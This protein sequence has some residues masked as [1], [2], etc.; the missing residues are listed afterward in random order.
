MASKNLSEVTRH[1]LITRR[2]NQ[3]YSLA[4]S[5]ALLDE[6]LQAHSGDNLAHALVY[7]GFATEARALKV[8]EV[9]A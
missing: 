4:E 7:E 8:A 5:E 1:H 2:S 6:L 9:L 3:G